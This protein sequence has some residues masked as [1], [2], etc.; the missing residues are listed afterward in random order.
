MKDDPCE[1]QSECAHLLYKDGS[2]VG[3]D[4]GIGSWS[5]SIPMSIPIQDSTVVYRQAEHR[6]W[7]RFCFIPIAWLKHR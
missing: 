2:C 6:R 7:H 5:M 4:I 1:R 3:S